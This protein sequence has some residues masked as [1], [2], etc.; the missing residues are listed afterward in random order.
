MKTKSRA[1][2]VAVLVGCFSLLLSANFAAADDPD[3]SGG[4]LSLPR[5]TINKINAMDNVKMGLDLAKGTFSFIGLDSDIM[6][7][8]KVTLSGGQ[9]VP[10]NLTPGAARGVFMVN[11]VTGTISGTVI[12]ATLPN[13]TAA[14]IHTGAVGVSGPV[15]IPLIGD[16]DIRVVPQNAFLTVEQLKSFLLSGLYVNVHTTGFPNGAIRGQL[17]PALVERSVTPL[18]G[19]D[20]VPPTN[21]SGS[22]LGVLNVD[23]KTRAISGRLTITGLTN[24]TGAG[25]HE[26]AVGANGPSI[27]PL[28]GDG[29]TMTVPTGAMLTDSQFNNFMTGGLYLNVYTGEFPGGE[30]RGQLYPVVR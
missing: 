5:V 30:I 26:G 28:L 25:I 20:S 27:I 18:R 17:E 15:I 13:V 10:P 11:T 4:V 21:S 14:H 29:Q 16:G 6:I 8:T 24:V 23:F 12:I 3:Y 19:A 22:A 2:I 7:T 1:I 9:E